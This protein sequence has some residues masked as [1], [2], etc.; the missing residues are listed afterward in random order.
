MVANPIREIFEARHRRWLAT[1]GEVDSCIWEESEDNL[2]GRSGY[3]T[4][5]FAYKDGSSDQAYHGHFTCSGCV[6]VKPYRT[7]ERVSVLYNP[8][9][10]ATYYC[11]GSDSGYE[12]VEAILVMVLFA[13]IAGYLL[14]AF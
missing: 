10:P 2:G 6:R 13:L 14:Y 9:R 12:K 11:F 4:V 8:K 1:Q 7:G 3:Y 5:T